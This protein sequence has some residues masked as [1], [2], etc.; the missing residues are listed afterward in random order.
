MVR[1]LG[2]EPAKQVGIDPGAAGADRSRAAIG[3]R[4]Q[5]HIRHQPPRPATIDLATRSP[6]MPPHLAAT[7][8]RAL[9]KDLVDR[10]HQ[11]QRLFRF[12]HRRVAIGRAA[13]Y[14]QTALR[15]D[16]QTVMSRLTVAHLRSMP[17]NRRL[18]LKSRSS[19]SCLLLAR[20]F[21][22]SLSLRPWPH[23]PLQRRSAIL[24]MVCRFQAAIIMW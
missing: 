19:A 15:R 9:H 1:S 6:R 2:R 18:S 14:Q 7:V 4:R 12:R 3:K 21:S 5:A 16:R 10:R 11:R 23:H 24:A 17:I 8:S 13:D 20:S 22:S